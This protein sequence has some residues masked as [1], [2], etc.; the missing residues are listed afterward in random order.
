M[1]SILQTAAARPS[2]ANDSGIFWNA[3][4]CYLGRAEVR[5][6]SYYEVEMALTGNVEL[7]RMPTQNW[8]CSLLVSQ[9]TF[10][11]IRCH[12]RNRAHAKIT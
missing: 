1:S 2:E 8:H 6:S 5:G 11:Q 12:A 9:L 10:A 7:Q 4:E 3:M